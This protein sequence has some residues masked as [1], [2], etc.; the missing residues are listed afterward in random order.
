[1]HMSHNVLLGFLWSHQIKKHGLIKKIM[2][3]LSTNLW[4]F[5]FV[6]ARDKY[7]GLFPPKNHYTYFLA[8]QPKIVLCCVSTKWHFYQGMISVDLSSGVMRYQYRQ[9]FENCS[10]LFGCL[11]SVIFSRMYEGTASEHTVTG[12]GGCKTVI[13]RKTNLPD[14]GNVL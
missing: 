14:T 10:I 7:W 2:V 13:I 1:M 8:W 12:A 6:V 3:Y 5:L 11:R 4:F 9:D